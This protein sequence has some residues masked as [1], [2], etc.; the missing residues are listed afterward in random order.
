MSTYVPT[1][2]GIGEQCASNKSTASLKVDL[3]GLTIAKDVVVCVR[4]QRHSC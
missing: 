1:H 4:E 2:G 3:V